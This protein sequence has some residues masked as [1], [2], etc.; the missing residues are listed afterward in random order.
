[1]RLEQRSEFAVTWWPPGLVRVETD[2]RRRDIYD[3]VY[4]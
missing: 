3:R 2:S 1:L 4:R